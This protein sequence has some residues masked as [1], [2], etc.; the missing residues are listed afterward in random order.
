MEGGHLPSLT[1][2]ETIAEREGVPAE[3]LQPPL[4]DA[5]DADALDAL[6]GSASRERLTIEFTYCG[7]TVR[8]TGDGEV[9]V[10][11]PEPIDRSGKEAV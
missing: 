7:Y 4:H 6:V 9:S 2:V 11:D 10:L 3:E 8:V 5:V 1:V